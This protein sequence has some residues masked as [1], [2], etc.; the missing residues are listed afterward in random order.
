MNT[1]RLEISTCI[2]TA[3]FRQDHPHCERHS[4]HSKS[5]APCSQI[6]CFWREPCELSQENRYVPPYGDQD[7]HSVL[8]R[9]KNEAGVP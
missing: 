1:L 3:I 4:S 9:A 5:L 7:E 6:E 8:K 2:L